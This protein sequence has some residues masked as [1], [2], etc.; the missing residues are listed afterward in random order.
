MGQRESRHP[1]YPSLKIQKIEVK[2]DFPSNSYFSDLEIRKMEFREIRWDCLPRFWGPVSPF[3]K[4]IL[5]LL[6]QV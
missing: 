2:I 4:V 1:L 5:F 6:F 3:W